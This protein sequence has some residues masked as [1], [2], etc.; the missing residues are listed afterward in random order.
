LHFHLFFWFL[1]LRQF[2]GIARAGLC[3]AFAE[4]AEISARGGRFFFFLLL[5]RRKAQP[6][7]PSRVGGPGSTSAFLLIPSPPRRP[8]SD[9]GTMRSSSG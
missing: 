2:G 1:F 9:C 6:A 5:L 3:L 4:I 7:L 8:A